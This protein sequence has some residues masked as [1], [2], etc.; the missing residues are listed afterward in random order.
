MNP[1]ADRAGVVG[2]HRVRRPRHGVQRGH[3]GRADRAGAPGGLRQGRRLHAGD[4][5]GDADRRAPRRPGAGAGLPVRPLDDGRSS[6]GS[7]PRRRRRG[8]GERRPRPDRVDPPRADPAAPEVDVLIPTRNRPVELA[9]TLAGLA[10]QEHPFDVVI[11]DQSD[12]R[13]VV[14]HPAG[15][16]DA[17]GAARGGAPGADGGAP[18]PGTASP[19][20]GRPCWR[21]STARYASSSTTTSGSSRARSRGC[22][23]RSP[24][25][26]AGSSARRCRACR[27]ST[28][29][30]PP[31]SPRSS[32]GRAAPS[33][34]GSRPT[35][36]PGT[37]GCCTTPRTRCTWPQEHVPAGGAVGAVQDRVGGR[38]RALRPGQ[39]R[40]RR[41][42]RLLA[43]PAA[44]ALRRGR[45]RQRAG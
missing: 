11:S 28:T 4:A 31:S 39:A 34:S 30:A 25:S 44:G 21:R 32:G 36:R 45:G 5:A 6:P 20:T 38:L 37:A 15:A 1:L 13:A 3:P 40:R 2:A 29:A 8:P 16:D 41:R 33:P 12:G 42:V 24:S 7:A 23:R 35:P 43:R 26:A 22:T 18:P 10:A 27:S 14:R 19:S 17:A 9:T